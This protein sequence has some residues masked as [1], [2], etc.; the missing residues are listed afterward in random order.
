MQMHAC[1]IYTIKYLKSQANS[2]RV[3]QQ[4][5]QQRKKTATDRVEEYDVDWVRD[6]EKGLRDESKRINNKVGA[7]Q[8]F[9]YHKILSAIKLDFKH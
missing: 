9:A 1:T 3:E 6:R 2:K 7:V 5:Q 8:R 4:Q